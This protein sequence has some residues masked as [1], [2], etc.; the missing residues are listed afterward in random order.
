[1]APARAAL[2][3]VVLASG[4]VATFPPG[5]PFARLTAAADLTAPEFA[6]ALQRKYEGIKDFSADFVHAYEGGVLRKLITERGR[7]L[8]KKPGRMRWEY[9]APEEKVF[10]SDGVKM[11]SYIPEDK[12]VIVATIP[13]QDAATTPTLFLAGKGNLTR[14]FTPSLVDLPAGMPAGS[15]S[16]KLVPKSP[17][18]EY[19]WLVL[20][21]DPVT[22]GLRGLVTVDAQGGKSSFSFKNLKEN[23]GLTDKDFAFKIPRGVDVVTAS[24]PP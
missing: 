12:Q 17:Q 7:L 20:V 2:A 5:T 13:P 6:Q 4:M 16:L 1:M 8:V 18:R 22:L 21:V 3:M 23:V 9:A 19:D 15:R 24:S 11:Y 14:D 10:V